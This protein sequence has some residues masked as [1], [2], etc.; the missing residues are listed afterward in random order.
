MKII[1]GFI[2]LALFAASS[3]AGATEEDSSDGKYLLRS[4]AVSVRIFDNLLQNET[5]D[6]AWRHGLCSGLVAGIM[7]ASPMVCH[8]PGVSVEQG[9]RVVEKF[10]RDHPEKLRL[11]GTRLANEALSQS[12]P[13]KQ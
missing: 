11:K 2:L 10:L 9:I 12:F 8:E 13:C 5:I 3:K 7:F 1:L 4:C 6:D